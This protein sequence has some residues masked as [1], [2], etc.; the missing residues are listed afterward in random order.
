MY[1]CVDILAE[2][3]CCLSFLQIIRKPHIWWCSNYSYAFRKLTWDISFSLRFY[4]CWNKLATNHHQCLHLLIHDVI[5]FHTIHNPL[6][7]KFSRVVNFFFFL[8][9]PIKKRE[10]WGSKQWIFLTTHSNTEKKNHEKEKC[11][12]WGEE[13]S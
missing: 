11:W 5:T 2:T 8:F 9:L 3:S 13:N 10:L 12:N 6:C 7:M 4:I 1:I